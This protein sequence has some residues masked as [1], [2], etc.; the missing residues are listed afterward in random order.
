MICSDKKKTQRN[1]SDLQHLSISS[2][3]TWG[4]DGHRLLLLFCRLGWRSCCR[5]VGVIQV[6]DIPWKGE[7]TEM[8]I[9]CRGINGERV[10]FG[11]FVG[12]G[13]GEDTK[14]CLSLLDQFQRWDPLCI[15]LQHPGSIVG[16]QEAVS[17][18]RTS[19]PK[20]L[21]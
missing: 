20:W 3:L 10:P 7:V 16:S 19:G 15:P 4:I 8:R 12:C 9:T 1:F 13:G 5:F 17:Y 21:Q 11:H 14:Y 18:A 6:G 2:Q